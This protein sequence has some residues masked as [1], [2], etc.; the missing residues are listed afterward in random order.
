MDPSDTTDDFAL[1]PPGVALVK[2]DPSRHVQVAV[3]VPLRRLFTYRVSNELSAELVPGARVAVPF[4]KRK[5]AGFVIAEADGPPPGVKRVLSVAGLLEEQTLFPSELLEFLRVA[6]DYY[7][8]P[9]GEVLRAAAPALPRQAM[10]ALKD[11]GFLQRDDEI[12]GSRSEMRRELFARFAPGVD[13]AELGRLGSRQAELVARVSAQGEVALTSVGAELRGARSIAR[14]L[15]ARGL[16]VLEEREVLADPFLGSPVERDQPPELTA[17]QADAVAAIV[18][19]LANPRPSSFLLHGVTGSG[20]TEVYLRVIAALPENRGAL[21][22]VP[23]IALT[24]QLVSRFRARFG[25]EI[26]V[27]HS[28]LSERA[29]HE[30]WHLLRRGRLRLAIGARSALF[31][32]VENLGVIVV[33]EE[34]D[35]SFKQEEGFRYNARD[36]ALLRA[37][38]AGAICILGSATPAVETYHLIT[39]DRLRLLKLTHRATS[40]HLPKVET[41]DLGRHRSGP[42]G[43]SLISAPLHRALEACLADKAQAILFLNRRGFAPSLR[44]AA[45]GKVVECP[46]C[47]VALTEHRRALVLRCHYCDYATPPG[48]TCSECGNPSLDRIGA[49]TEQV[50]S[51]LA[52][53]FPTARVARLD[54]DTASARGVE[55]VLDRMRAGE[56]DIL[57]GT[58]MVTKGHDLPNVTLV[59]VILADQSMAFPDFR[60]TERTFQ[61]LSQVAGRAGRGDRPGRVLIQTYQP[62]HAAITLAARHDYLGFYH[63]EIAARRELGYPP[64]SRLVA[65]R[66]D[67]AD[68][69][70]AEAAGHLLADL[71]RTQPAVVADRVRVLGPAPAPIARLRARYRYRLLL[72]GADLRALRQ[73][74]ATLLRRS[75]AGLGMARATVDIDPVSML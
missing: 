50:E 13:L 68:L 60:A 33:D 32:P 23:E 73:V 26:A 66:V 38:R 63:H 37:Q 7:M 53:A 21:V 48:E 51:T 46:A 12:K 39:R 11:R 27:L 35:S 59:G 24:P 40:H 70:Q 14:R 52:A 2:A 1:K 41:V 71:A 56:I 5:V 69:E 4:G 34:H 29:R 75:E 47:S 42:S 49:G 9:V 44:C 8:H 10:K 57:V 55:T 18:A 67:A 20:K 65:I 22:L 36:L 61:L 17:E 16:L 45:C 74:A 64:F 72:R 19:E 25:N 43:H 28:G 6:A 31:A 54:R 30:A 15:E 3:P 62:E 58:Q